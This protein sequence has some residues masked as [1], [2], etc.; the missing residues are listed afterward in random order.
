MLNCEP[1]WLALQASQCYKCWSWGHTQRFCK[2]SALCPR[3]GTA[4]HVGERE[5]RGRS[6]TQPVATRFL[7]SVHVVQGGT[8]SGYGGARKQLKS[9]VQRG[10]HA[11]SGPRS[12]SLPCSNNNNNSNSYRKCDMLVSGARTPWRRP[13]MASKKQEKGRDFGVD[14]PIFT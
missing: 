10:R 14:P 5:G 3:C 6:N 4:A 7:S 11:I 8:R 1:Y 9:G 13:T 2:K 12:L